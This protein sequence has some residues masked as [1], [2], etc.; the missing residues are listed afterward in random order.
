M[1]AERIEAV[2]KI[3]DTPERKWE[4]RP[5]RAKEKPVVIPFDSMLEQAISQRAAIDFVDSL[6]GGGLRK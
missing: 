5:A 4:R 3:Y 2:K 6:R 1:T